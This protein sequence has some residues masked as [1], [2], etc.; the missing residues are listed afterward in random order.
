MNVSED[1]HLVVHVVRRSKRTLYLVLK[2]FRILKRCRALFDSL[3][4][5]QLVK[6]TLLQWLTLGLG[7][8]SSVTMK[9]YS[10][11]GLYGS[12]IN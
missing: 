10:D 4:V 12:L 3:L 5:R 7:Y 8:L 11:V 2:Y 6:L 1:D 9:L